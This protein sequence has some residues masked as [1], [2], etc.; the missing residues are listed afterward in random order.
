MSISCI[1]IAEN[2]LFID[3]RREVAQLFHKRQ[4]NKDAGP[5]RTQAS[6]K[7]RRQ[8]E[9]MPL[10][11]YVMRKMQPMDGRASHTQPCG[12]SIYSDGTKM[13]I[14][15]THKVVLYKHQWRAFRAIPRQKGGSGT[16]RYLRCCPRPSQPGSC[17]SV[18]FCL[19]RV[20][21]V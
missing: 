11:A 18:G 3:C 14:C 9:K 17:L 13:T 15:V 2:R 1:Q 19:Y 4:R 5:C 10:S 20:Q 8:P 16:S 6:V 7:P 21:W 12:A